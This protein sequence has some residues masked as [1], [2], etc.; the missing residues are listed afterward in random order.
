MLIENDAMYPKC[1]EAEDT[2][3]HLPAQCPVKA[4]LA[5][6]RWKNEHRTDPESHSIDSSEWLRGW[7]IPWKVKKVLYGSLARHRSPISYCYLRIHFSDKIRRLI[8]QSNDR[9]AHI[10]MQWY[11]IYSLIWP[12]IIGDGRQHMMQAL[13]NRQRSFC[14][15][16]H[17]LDW[18]MIFLRLSVERLT[19][20][21][22]LW[23]SIPEW[24]KSQRDIDPS[25]NSLTLNKFPTVFT[26]SYFRMFS[27]P[28][29]KYKHW[30]FANHQ[31]QN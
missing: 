13:T 2:S 23:N 17:Y 31:R 9:W 7:V 6:S 4:P 10:E 19:M 30:C 25:N 3:F 14:Q 29:R 21:P 18:W 1:T 5:H 24:T 8:L 20:L 26:V 11:F 28:T 12:R 27:G 15:S 22:S 16:L